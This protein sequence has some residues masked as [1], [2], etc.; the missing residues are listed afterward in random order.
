MCPFFYRSL[1]T[2]AT[3]QQPTMMSSS[4][5]NDDEFFMFF[6][7]V[8]CQL[9][10]LGLIFSEAKLKHFLSSAELHR[11]DRRIRRC[12]LVDSNQSPF[13]K[14]YLSGN[15]HSIITYTGLDYVTFEDLLSKFQPLYQ[16]YS[17]Y[18]VNGKIARVIQQDGMPGRKRLLYAPSCLG[19]VL[20]YTRTKGSLVSLQMIFGAT[21]SVL[22][23]FLHYSIKL[24]TRY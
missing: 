11:R 13:Q 1:C 16:C 20:G 15:D 14:L 19:L 5:C 3:G 22:A 6:F 23:L 9:P 8:S 21:H 7:L 10:L 17:P 12:T 18:S 2:T 4:S 24:L